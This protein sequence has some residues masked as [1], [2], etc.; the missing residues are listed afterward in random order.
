[1]LKQ[2]E[3]SNSNQV[4]RVERFA[5]D[6]PAF[7]NKDLSP[8]GYLESGSEFTCDLYDNETSVRSNN[9]S[10]LNV[11]QL[12]D[13]IVIESAEIIKSV[14]IYNS[15]GIKVFESSNEFFNNTI[16]IT[17]LGSSVYFLKIYFENN[18]IYRKII[19]N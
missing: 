2:G 18:I 11:E 7:L 13:R 14:E 6:F 4:F 8:M 10:N 12:S 9:Q 3:T 17:N 1:M 15:I 5:K 19:I 16:N